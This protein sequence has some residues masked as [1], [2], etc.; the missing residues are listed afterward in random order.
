MAIH[1]PSPETETRSSSDRLALDTDVTAVLDAL[2]D[3]SC[4]QILQLVAD[5]PFTA[6]EIS[7]RCDMPLSTTYRKL[8]RLTE[9]SLVTEQTRVRSNGKHASEYE[10]VVDDVFIELG[11]DGVDLSVA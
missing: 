10:R 7:E 3:E 8:E 6:T 2:D 11:D 9:A 5:Q 4:R 1:P